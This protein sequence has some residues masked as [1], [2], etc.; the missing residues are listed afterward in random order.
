M[1]SSRVAGEMEGAAAA[2]RA[3]AASESSGSFFNAA[4][5]AEHVP[6]WSAMPANSA[7]GNSPRANAASMFELGQTT[8]AIS[9][10]GGGRIW[11][12]GLN[13]TKRPKSVGNRFRSL[14]SKRQERQKNGHGHAHGHE[15]QE[16]SSLQSCQRATRA[17]VPVCVPVPV[18]DLVFRLLS[19]LTPVS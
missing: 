8:T 2:A 14:C 7:S 6:M 5:H 15:Q 3:R 11:S 12:S 16:V 10:S 17:F 18:P 1:L 13:G 19:F 4:A 9:G